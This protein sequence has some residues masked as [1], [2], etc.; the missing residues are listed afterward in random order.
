MQL[1]YSIATLSGGPMSI[2][3]QYVLLF[4]TDRVS[5]G[6]NVVLYVSAYTR[7]MPSRTSAFDRS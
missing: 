5:P 6:A 7:R 4:D 2:T 3:N 1:R